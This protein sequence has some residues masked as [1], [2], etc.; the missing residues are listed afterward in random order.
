[1]KR[2]A[3]WALLTA[4]VLIGVAVVFVRFFV[5]EPLRQTMERNINRQLQGYTVHI[6]ALKFHPLGGSLD[7]IDA[8]I[9]QD[10]HPDPPVAHLP[11]LHASVNWQAVLHRRLVA[12]FLIDRPK[13]NINL[14]QAKQEVEEKTSMADRGWQDT[15]EQIYP[16]KVNLFRVKDAEITYVDQGPFKPLHL[17]RVNF[18]ASNI[19]NIHSRDNVYPSDV[20]LEAIVFGSGKVVVDGHADFLAKPHAGIKA[21][22]SVK[23]L[24]LDYFK[25]ILSHVNF[26]IRNGVLSS[27][28]MFEYAPA[29]KVASLQH[30]TVQG[31]Q[32]GF[33]HRAETET[34]EKQMGEKVARNAKDVSNKPGVLLR[35][36]QVR[37]LKSRF[38][39]TN[40]AS[41]PRYEIFFTD[42]DLKLDNLSNQGAEGKALGTLTGNFMGSGKTVI[43]VA[44]Q[45]KA[46]SAD[47][48]LKLR[49]DETKMTSMN[50][51]F[52]AHA[53]FDVAEGRFS[54]YSELSVRDGEINGYV[55]PLFKDVSVYDEA[56]DADKPFS[57]RLRQ[58]LIGAAAWILSNRQRNE[59]A[60]TITLSGKLDSPQ[61]SNWEAFVGMVKNA[62]FEAVTPGFEQAARVASNSGQ[63]KAAAPPG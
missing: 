42:A 3:A 19:R 27:D 40:E 1:M 51:A 63:Q 10:A 60:T 56:K 15:L 53:K 33:V 34:A 46:K 54:L 11:L 22:F 39:F 21:D 25:P 12:D 8:T 6:R 29:Q 58:R 44:F 48:D 18:Q 49:I 20:R 17:S 47:F 30:V 45:P 41:D 24:E 23:Q 55:K 14:K 38:T 61:Y 50:N 5:D 32:V 37:I 35:V 36:D 2:I 13:L 7:L 57:Q 43:N 28:G 4:V 52:L 62:F 16:L 59:V 9:S 26:S 31:V